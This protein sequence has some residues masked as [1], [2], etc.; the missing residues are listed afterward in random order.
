MSFHIHPA[1]KTGKD[2]SSRRLLRRA[3]HMNSF[4]LDQC[5]VVHIR[6]TRPSLNLLH[7]LICQLIMPVSSSNY[8]PIS[9]CSRNEHI[10][11][12]DSA[13]QCIKGVPHPY[14][15]SWIMAS[16][17]HL[18]SDQ[19]YRVSKSGLSACSMPQ[20]LTSD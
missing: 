10:I 5:T 9:I 18:D 12:L 13:S 15:Y 7:P 2:S 20:T 6:E 8:G 17:P 16:W 4:V 19:Q 1:M 3:K 14:F 11:F